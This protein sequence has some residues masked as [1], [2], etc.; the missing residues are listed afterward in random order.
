MSALEKQIR[1]N[2]EK[3]NRTKGRLEESEGLHSRRAALAA[4]V[5]EL[6]RITNGETLERDAIDRLYELF[7]ECRDKQLGTLMGPIHDRVLNW[8]RVLDIGDYSEMRFNE[9][10]LPDK[11][12]RRD[13]TAEFMIDEESTG[14]QEQIGLL[15]RLALGTLLT[16]VNEPTVA[17]LDDPLTHCDV[18]RINKMRS[19]SPPC[20]RRRYE[21]DSTGRPIADYCPYLPSG[22]VS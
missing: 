6:G 18:S 11:L 22:V 9:A 19:D 10:F 4:R 21:A 20:R 8:M 3:Y 13:G 7:E 12:V 14:A 2:E 15:V 1:E 16:S 17:I 5:D